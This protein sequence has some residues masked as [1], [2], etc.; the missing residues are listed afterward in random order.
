MDMILRWFL[1]PFLLLFG[2]SFIMYL[3]QSLQRFGILRTKIFDIKLSTRFGLAGR[4]ID[5]V[6]WVNGVVISVL[7]ILAIPLFLLT[8]DIRG[9][10]RRYGVDTA[11]D[12]KID[13]EENYLRAAQAICERNP[14]TA[15]Y[16]YGHTHV[17]SLRTIGSR[18]VINTGTWL[19]R[20][21]R[22]RA[23]FRLMPDV[24]V[25]SYQL[26]YFTVSRQGPRI[27][28][29]YRIIPKQVPDDLTLLQRLMILGRRRTEGQQIPEETFL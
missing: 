29:G 26:N 12:L 11:E 3:G 23:H 13:K 10:L 22:A 20:L 7:L 25:P 5:W 18:C 24:Y 6:I 14:S 17:P 21:E 1:L 8:Q 2:V 15:I 9:A 19:K 16:I 28:V 27:R 4:L